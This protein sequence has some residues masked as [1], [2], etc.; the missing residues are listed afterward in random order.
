MKFVVDKALEGSPQAKSSSST[1]ALSEVPKFSPSVLTRG[2]RLCTTMLEPRGVSSM[3][4][5]GTRRLER[6]ERQGEG[7]QG[8][9]ASQT[10]GSADGRA[11]GSVG[12]GSLRGVQPSSGLAR[13]GGRCHTAAHLQPLSCHQQASPRRK[14]QSNATA[15]EHASSR[16]HRC[17]GRNTEA[18]R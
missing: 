16:Q 18:I 11:G 13:R 3:Q 4:S 1:P 2:C 6:G 5:L 14:L 15:I 17:A 7:S 12:E 9:R 8:G 10:C